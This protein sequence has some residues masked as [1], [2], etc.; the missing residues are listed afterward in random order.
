M[1]NLLFALLL[2]ACT[3]P[4]AAPPP[5][6][7]PPPP[8]DRPENAAVAAGIVRD[9]AGRAV[10]RARVTA[11]AADPSCT[12]RGIPQS[13][14][15]GEDGSYQVRVEA[16]VG[17]QFD[18]CIVLEA[19]AGGA[20]TKTQQSVRYA[21]DRAGGNDVRLDITLP[22]APPL[23]RAEADRLVALVVEAMRHDHEAVQELALYLGRSTTDTYSYLTP[24]AQR[25]RGVEAPPR[26][27]VQSGRTF[28]YELT[29]RRPGTSM[30][31]IV[32][33]DALTRV[34]VLE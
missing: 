10:E 14:V 19:A 24:F 12:P 5:A 17:P 29:G 30:R 6:S 15:T 3:A 9:A 1:R 18:G 34:D 23:T 13:V 33:Q 8:P 16:G 26:L 32:A 20:V 25:T 2:T 22:P 4:V 7:T 21:P 11:W 28:E 31:V 27:A